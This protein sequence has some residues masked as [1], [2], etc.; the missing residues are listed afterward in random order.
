MKSRKM[1][2]GKRVRDVCD[3]NAFRRFSRPRS[4]TLGS[5]VVVGSRMGPGS[6]T[7]LALKLSHQGDP[8]LFL[9]LLFVLETKNFF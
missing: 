6:G 1:T 7:Y 9:V 5:L 3:E 4:W 2:E 8:F